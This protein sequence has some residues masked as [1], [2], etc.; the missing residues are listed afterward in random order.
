MSGCSGRPS[1]L[2]ALT[3]TEQVHRLSVEQAERGIPTR[4]RAICTFS[5][6]FSQMLIV[7]QEKRALPIDTSRIEATARAAI[8]AG[9]DVEVEG[10]TG[11]TDSGNVVVA[12]VLTALS[13]GRWPEAESLRVSQLTLRDHAYRWVELEGMVRA[14]SAS[15]RASVSLRVFTPEGTFEVRVF[16]RTVADHATLV[17]SRVKV[18]GSPR[19]LVDS[20]GAVVRIELLV[21]SI[22]EV[23]VQ[24]RGPEDPFTLPVKAIHAL[25]TQSL[26]P[27]GG[28]R[29]RVRGIAQELRQGRFLVK[30]ES[31][32]IQ[33]S[34]AA[35]SLPPG[36]VIDVVGFPSG[37][38]AGLALED[39]AFR[40][41]PASAAR[42]EA[43][44]PAPAMPPVVRTVHA[45]H[46]LSAHDA[47]RG[48]PV[49][50]RGVLTYYTAIWRF[51]F[52][53]DA[54]GGIFVR[55][56][57]APFEP[58]PGQLLD[59]S[60]RTGEGEFAPV[61][62]GAQI[63][64]VG[65]APF[66]EPATASLD[67]LFT[68]QHDSDWVSAEGVVQSVFDES[69]HPGLVLLAGSHQFRAMLAPGA[70]RKRAAGLIDARVR[71]RG[72]C[73]TLFNDKRQLIGIQLFVPR[74]DQISVLDP[75]PDDP[76][77]QPLR[78]IATLMQFRPGEALDHRIRVQ[79]IV[80]LQEPDG[81]LF[82][83]DATGGLRVLTTG[84]GRLNLG[85]RVEAVGFAATG[86]Y[87]PVLQGSIVRR[88]GPGP[89]LPPVYIT[90][91]DALNGL[92]HGELVSIEARL[93]ERTI[94]PGEQV[95]TL[96]AGKNTFTAVLPKAPGSDGLGT[97]QPGSL[98][99]L[100]GI[101]FVQADTAR[102][103]DGQVAVSAFRLLLRTPADVETRLRASWWD[104]AHT[105]M[106]VGVMGL[107]I[108]SA[109]TWVFMLR[110]EVRRQTWAAEAAS[111]AKSE[112]L[113]NM[114]HEIRTPMNGIIGM[115]TLALETDLTRDQRECLSLVK[116]SSET[117]LLLMNQILDFSKIEVGKMHLDSIGFG[118]RETLTTTIR[119][120]ELEAKGR[121][122]SL[123]LHVD[124][125][126][127]E[128]L[129]GDSLRLR[130]IIINLVGNG[131]KFTAAGGVIVSV[132]QAAGREGE[133]DLL[134][135]VIDTGC[136]IPGDKQESIFEAFVQADASTN[137][138]YGGTG[139]GLAISSQLVK[140]MRGRIWVESEV[141]L[142]SAFHFTA[143]LA[144]GAALPAPAEPVT[145]AAP[146][147]AAVPLRV[148]LV[149]DSVVNQ[150]FAVRM[151]TRRGCTVT[152]ADNGRKG[153][154][155]HASQPFDLILMDVQMPEMDGL[156]ATAAIRQREKLTGVHVPIVAMTAYAMKGDRERCF[157]AGMDGYVSKPVDAG[158]LFRV[159]ASV[160]PRLGALS[161][162]ARTL[163]PAAVVRAASVAAE[164]VL[165]LSDLWARI[166][167]DE[168]F[169]REMVGLFGETCPPLL[170]EL[171][172]AVAGADGAA[173]AAVAHKLKG[174]AGALGGKRAAVVA[175][176]VEEA[177]RDGLRGASALVE[178]LRAELQCLEHELAHAGQIAAHS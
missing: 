108:L 146:D 174:V 166:E 58:I 71:V 154:A 3:S 148:L 79:G 12:S 157:E 167:G 50:L 91:E 116:S 29:V 42:S 113:A 64:L 10:V 104:L 52:V 16:G 73:G 85:D 99:R 118:L 77:L 6:E 5:D 150:S 125:D 173:V 22:E 75:A 44:L 14:T 18:R 87:T 17:D 19:I 65:Q 123:R 45:I 142:G 39:A 43:R 161:P 124:E 54:T 34:V 67:D 133:V 120:M 72:A 175:L 51:G 132:H 98:V 7:Q 149:E 4:F 137:R 35:G 131:L 151:L 82:I 141:G 177:G 95:L 114:S 49:R 111:R 68:G 163:A 106:V 134:F 152:V 96:Q 81:S 168:M 117:L 127:P 122:L 33:V 110:K 53:Q 112:F 144:L 171:E 40:E 164:P 21:P 165:D 61:I 76:F 103:Q 92:H 78:P 86:E 24:D 80:T 57:G 26:E 56:E 126:V 158:E 60:G 170:S 70:D 20:S 159:I 138:R 119:S 129:V 105:L 136:G 101:C 66:P 93:V 48:Y 109:F 59:I 153:L 84:Q 100:T 36:R 25:Q 31:G 38:G 9:Q 115:T 27:T 2:R 41:P 15:T 30:D 162:E 13:S 55:L 156:E 90:A 147:S 176:R 130:Q 28:H 11:H 23:R 69:G 107:L 37:T 121:G 32:A 63:R 102:R 47:S 89:A 143:T 160:R 62:D 178:D 140:L 1:S 74:L 83:S 172:A 169:L 128:T 135:S 155:Q 46:S 97:V 88:L 145:V 94:R 8:R 139:L